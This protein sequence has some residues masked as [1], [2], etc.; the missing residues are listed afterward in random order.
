[1]KKQYNSTLKSKV[2][3][4]QQDNI[5]KYLFIIAK[6]LEHSPKDHSSSIFSDQS[7]KQYARKFNFIDNIYWMLHHTTF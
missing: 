6:D 3:S 1:M 4:I 7:A 2:S 5:L